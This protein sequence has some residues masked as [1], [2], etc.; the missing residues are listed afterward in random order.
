MPGLAEVARLALQW[1]VEHAAVAVVTADGAV[2]A[3][4]GDLDRPF[5]LASV[6][7]LLTAYAVLVEVDA[8]TLR[9]DLPLG[10]EGSTLAHLAAHASGLPFEGVV[11]VARPGTR[12]IYSNA[13]FDLLGATVAAE[14]GM[15]FGGHLD[16]AVLT[17]LGMAATALTG[18]PAAAAVGT[19]TD[20][21]RFVAELQAPTLVR[22][23]SLAAAVSVAFPG[24]DGVLPGF[25]RQQPNDWGLGYEIR[26]RKQPH[27]TGARSSQRTFGHFGRAGTFLW[28]DPDAHAGCVALT[29]RDF[30]P[31]AATA[32]P[33]FTDAV[34]A[35]L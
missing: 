21:A 9:W 2:V 16:E 32:W 4:A 17:P 1:P 31:W 14:S 3:A 27:W 34:L 25:G 30:G 11:P 23:D 33:R 35:A 18:S 29:D 20:L 13:A 26:G 6:T 8:G 5:P 15:P 28:V 19:A 12:R 24:L 22:P 7:K 10:P